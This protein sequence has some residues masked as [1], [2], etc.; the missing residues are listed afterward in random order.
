MEQP[1]SSGTA[2]SSNDY[3]ALQIAW[4]NERCGR[5]PESL[6]AALAAGLVPAGSRARVWRPTPP[7]PRDCCAGMRRICCR[8]RTT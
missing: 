8:I 5:S 3:Y 2:S 7:A 1:S 6:F 4:T